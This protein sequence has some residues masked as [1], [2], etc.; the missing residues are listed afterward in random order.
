MRGSS[1]KIARFVSV[2]SIRKPGLASLSIPLCAG[3]VWGFE[4]DIPLENS[5]KVPSEPVKWMIGK[6]V[7]GQPSE[8]HHPSQKANILKINGL[9]TTK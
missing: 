6:M 5:F 2:I 8:N 7:F 4:D 9:F 3:V 1:N